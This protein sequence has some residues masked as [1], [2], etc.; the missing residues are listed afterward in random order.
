MNKQNN[1]DLLLVQVGL[2]FPWF[3]VVR[4][5]LDMINLHFPFIFVDFDKP[6]FF[7]TAFQQVLEDFRPLVS[8]KVN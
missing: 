6:Y 8:L 3:K 2:L 1:H 4:F 5:I 7:F